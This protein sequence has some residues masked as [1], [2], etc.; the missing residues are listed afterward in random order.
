[1]PRLNLPFRAAVAT[2]SGNGFEL[3]VSPG[4][5]KALRWMNE[6]DEYTWGTMRTLAAI[7]TDSHLWFPLL[8]LAAGVALLLRLV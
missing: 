7:L 8:V 5:N 3:V 4:V 6:P 1:M 2:E